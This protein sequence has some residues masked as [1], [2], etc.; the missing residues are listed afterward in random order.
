MV[1]FQKCV[2]EHLHLCVWRC[3]Y[4]RISCKDLKS[5]LCQVNYRVPNMKFLREKLPVTSSHSSHFPNTPSPPVCVCFQCHPNPV[6]TLPPLLLLFLSGLGVEEWRRVL[7]PVFPALSQPDVWRPESCKSSS[8]ISLTP[9]LCLSASQMAPESRGLLKPTEPLV[10]TV[11]PSRQA[12]RRELSCH[13]ETTR[14]IVLNN[15]LYFCLSDG[16]SF[17]TEVDTHTPSLSIML[18]C[19]CELCNTSLPLSGS[20]RDQ[21]RRSY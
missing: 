19:R 5:M 10:G 14:F 17:S 7:Q 2:C 12:D 21:S 20:L 9:S 11:R 3:V 15:F 18:Y 1:L 6:A 16:D 8:A 13:T 4:F